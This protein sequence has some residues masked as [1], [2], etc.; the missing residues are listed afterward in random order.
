[1]IF[2]AITLSGSRESV[3]SRDKFFEPDD[4]EIDLVTGDQLVIGER[5]KTFG[6]DPGRARLTGSA[7]LDEVIE[8]LTP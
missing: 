8:M 6:F 5:P 4:V 3:S 7:A 2:R 1:M